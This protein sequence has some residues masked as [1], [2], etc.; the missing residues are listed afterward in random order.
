MMESAYNMKTLHQVSEQLEEE[1]KTE[2]AATCMKLATFLTNS[3][4]R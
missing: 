2:H 3:V 1:P 4:G